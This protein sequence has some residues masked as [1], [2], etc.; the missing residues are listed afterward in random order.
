MP[1][2]SV[3]GIKS[4]GKG[5]PERIELED[6]VAGDGPQPKKGQDVSFHY[7]GWL[8]L[9][10]EGRKGRV[11]RVKGQV[12]WPSK[13]FDMCKNSLQPASATDYGANRRLTHHTGVIR[14]S[15]ARSESARCKLPLQ[16]VSSRCVP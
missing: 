7:T 5:G 3:S 16:H 11:Q 6:A 1:M 4:G 9:T 14:L 2:T 15:N 10:R 13:A 12:N 8:A